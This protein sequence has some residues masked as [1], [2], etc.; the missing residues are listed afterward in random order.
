[1]TY[2]TRLQIL[3]PLFPIF[4]KWHVKVY[5]SLHCNYC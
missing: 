4:V 5:K 1:M 3:Y 2:N